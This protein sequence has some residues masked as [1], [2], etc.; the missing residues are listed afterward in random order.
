MDFLIAL[1]E[2]DTRQA[3]MAI[4]AVGRIA[5][6]AELRARVEKAVEQ[7]GSPRLVQAFSQHLPAH[8]E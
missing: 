5:P 1:I 7:A 6:N 4:E 3:S 8:P 2:G